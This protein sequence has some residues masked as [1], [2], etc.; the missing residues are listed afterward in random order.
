MEPL[1]LPEFDIP[2]SA[3]KRVT[4]TA[5]VEWVIGNM[6]LYEKTV[7]IKRICDQPERRPVDVRFVLK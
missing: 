2:E 1:K 4:L 5:F 7:D 6:K 3:P